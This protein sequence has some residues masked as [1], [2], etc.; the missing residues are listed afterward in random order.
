MP[1]SGLVTNFQ[2]TPLIFVCYP[3]SGASSGLRQDADDMCM[4]C[5]TEAL[6]PIPSIQLECGHVFHYQ[7][8]RK[9]LENRWPGPRITF[10]FRNC[11]ICKTQVGHPS[12]K[13]LLDP[14][15]SLY[16]DVKK[17][18]LMRLEYEGN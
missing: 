12:L 5:F 8:V 10:G 16:E 13:Q 14:I 6:W 9:I 15:D 4:I 7:C 17:K 11:P 1:N 2:D 18:A 3:I